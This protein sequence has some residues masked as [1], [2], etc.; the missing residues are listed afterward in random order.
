MQTIQIDSLGN[1]ENLA[2]GNRLE[3]DSTFLPYDTSMDLIG[4]SVKESR[5]TNVKVK[6]SKKTK[7]KLV[8][9]HSVE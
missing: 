1:I 9:K 8:N 5:S 2:N 7:H 6:K 4:S 3:M